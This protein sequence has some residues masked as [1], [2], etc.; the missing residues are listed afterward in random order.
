MSDEEK[1]F[2]TTANLGPSRS[3]CDL[4]LTPCFHKKQEG[5]RMTSP[6]HQDGRCRK[7]SDMH[8]AHKVANLSPAKNLRLAMRQLVMGG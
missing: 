4:S 3:R 1:S 2:V 8:G 5:D 6:C 7:N